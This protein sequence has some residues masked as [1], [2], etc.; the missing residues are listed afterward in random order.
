VTA[1]ETIIATSEIEMATEESGLPFVPNTGIPSVV[2]DSSDASMVLIPEG[3]FTMGSDNGDSDEKPVHTVYL[4]DFYIDR[5][6]VTNAL[7]KVCV[8]EGACNKPQNTGNYDNPNY[9]DHPVVYVDWNMAQAYC[10]WRGAQLPT[11]AQ[12]EKAARGIDERT[13]PW[14]E[15]ISCSKANYLGCVGDTKPIG[16]YESNISP[17]GVYDMAGN[18]WEWVADWYSEKYDQNSS[19]ENP[20]G[21]DSG[22]YRVLRGGAWN[23]DEYLLRTSARLGSEPSDVYLSFGFRCASD[24]AP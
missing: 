15:G 4:N 3:E 6:E 20:L 7:Y 22:Q 17:Y 5:Y 16:S 14:G 19:A 2:P 11:E 24:E 12:W 1:A 9:A 18:V 21:P 8:T 23:Q 10:E 13:Y